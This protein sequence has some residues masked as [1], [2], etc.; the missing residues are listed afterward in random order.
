MII[1]SSSFEGQII[2]RLATS[3]ERPLRGG[4]GEGEGRG[5]RG[6]EGEKGEVWFRR[7]RG[8]GGGY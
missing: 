8:I 3:K 4:R 6:R 2:S 1:I 7:G 5:G